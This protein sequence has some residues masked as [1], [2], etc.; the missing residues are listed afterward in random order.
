MSFFHYYPE[1]KE[2]I[3]MLN[4]T[5][6]L[7]QSYSVKCPCSSGIYVPGCVTGSRGRNEHLVRS[8]FV[9]QI[10]NKRSS[11]S[12]LVNL[13]MKV[14]NSPFRSSAK[15]GGTTIIKLQISAWFLEKMILANRGWKYLRG[16]IF[17]IYVHDYPYSGSFFSFP[18]LLRPPL[19][20][21]YS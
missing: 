21:Q 16:L 18:N 11:V 19:E 1:N 3:V 2:C 6:R 4:I 15:Y 7:I 9:D 10:V 14:C 20:I 13:F 17:S 5:T 12:R 8:M